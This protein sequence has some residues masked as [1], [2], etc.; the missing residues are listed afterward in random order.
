MTP[1]GTT[2]E[3]ACFISYKRPPKKAGE[4]H[5]YMEFVE[6]F[7]ERLEFYLNTSIRSYVDTQADPGFSYP[8]EI[9]R[10]LCKSVCMIAIMVPEYPDSNWCRAEYEAMEKLE[11]LRIKGER[12]LIIPIALRRTAS[13]WNAVLKRKPV[14]FS[15]VSVPRTQLNNIKHSQKIQEIADQIIKLVAEVKDPCED[16]VNFQFSVGI[17]E[18]SDQPTFTDPNPFS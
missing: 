11:Q 8:T 16:C 14:D 1:V 7:R 9:S 6:T 3:H 5:F 2:F 4:N 12:R 17:E 15:R 10:E 13:E 18:L